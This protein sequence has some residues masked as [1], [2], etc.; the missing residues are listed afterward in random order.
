MSNYFWKIPYLLL[1][2]HFS[3]APPTSDPLADFK[4]ERQKYKALRKQQGTKGTNREDITLAILDKFKT[5]L[6]SARSLAGDYDD[7]EEEEKVP[8]E[9]EEE[10]DVND[11]SW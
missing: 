11:M 10:E 8:E 9:E 7:E 5:K 4:K 6:Q 1:L 2:H 3:G